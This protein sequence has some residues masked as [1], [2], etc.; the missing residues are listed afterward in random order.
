VVT[1]PNPEGL[2]L[3]RHAGA[4]LVCAALWFTSCSAERAMPSGAH[5]DPRRHRPWRCLPGDHF[6][7]GDGDD[8]GHAGMT[9]VLARA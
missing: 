3:F 8:H 6:D 4:I 7:D 2:V 5:A 1:R 9:D